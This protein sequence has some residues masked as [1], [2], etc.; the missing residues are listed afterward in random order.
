MISSP[1]KEV[2][3]KVIPKGNVIYNMG[4]SNIAI[5]NNESTSVTIYGDEEVLAGIEYIPVEID[6]DGLAE[7]NQYKVELVKPT[8]IKYMSVTTATIDV[9]LSDDITNL[10]IEGV[11]ISHTNLT[12]GLGV[13]PIDVDSIAVKI[14]G[15]SS[16]VQDITADD[17]TAYVDLDGLAVGEHE[18]DV[19]VSG[20]DSRVEY[21]S[22]VLK[23][24][25]K[26]F[27][28]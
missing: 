22:S 10:D 20:N 25:V 6:I 28:K 26:I 5:N 15:V 18:V 7:S 1:S 21:Q 24:K 17:I 19:K 4:I 16:I 3:I 8:G 11:G 27:E 23:I 13:T 9:T 12:S 2:P 14:K